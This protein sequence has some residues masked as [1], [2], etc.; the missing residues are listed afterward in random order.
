M[1]PACSA[2]TITPGKALTLEAPADIRLGQVALSDVLADQKR[3]SLKLTYLTALNPHIH[4]EEDDEHEDDEEE[5]DKE[6]TVTLANLVPGVVSV[7][8]IRLILAQSQ[9]LWK[10]DCSRLDL[11]PS[12]G[13]NRLRLRLW[14]A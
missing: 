5:E 6:Y 4:D 1:A 11:L 14:V 2:F 9:Y 10:T 8:S 12:L 7:L 13:K 3:S